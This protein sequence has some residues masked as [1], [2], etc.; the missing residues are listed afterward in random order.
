[1]R[2]QTNQDDLR[3]SVAASRNDFE[4]ARP[5]CRRSLCASSV[6]A[7]TAEL[8]EHLQSRTSGRILVA[9]GGRITERPQSCR[10]P[11]SNS[12]EVY[13]VSTLP[14]PTMTSAALLGAFH[15]RIGEPRQRVNI[16][17]RADDKNFHGTSD[18]RS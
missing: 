16:N 14:R 11:S 5:S 12:R 13:V 10:T 4:S 15:D 1:M 17:A 18:L 7:S 9:S 8:L 3:P 6:T 2:P